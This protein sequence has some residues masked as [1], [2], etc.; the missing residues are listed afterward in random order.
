MEYQGRA[1]GLISFTEL[2][3]KNNLAHWGFYIGGIRCAY[4]SRL[5][6][7]ADTFRSIREGLYEHWITSLLSKTSESIEHIM[8]YHLWNGRKLDAVMSGRVMALQNH[9]NDIA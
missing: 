3:E 9:G 7:E 1:T 4:R 2:D 6:S 5:H 8:K